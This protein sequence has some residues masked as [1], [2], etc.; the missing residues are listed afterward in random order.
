MVQCRPYYRT[1]PIKAKGRFREN[2]QKRSEKGTRKQEQHWKMRRKYQGQSLDDGCGMRVGRKE[3]GE[4]GGGRFVG[5]KRVIFIRRRGV[6]K[7]KIRYDRAGM[8][9]QLQG[10]SGV[11]FRGVSVWYCIGLLCIVFCRSTVI[12]YYCCSLLNI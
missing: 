10:V 6:D 3:K 7:L 12:V 8:A 4:F 11:A 9:I 5:E 2:N 1:R